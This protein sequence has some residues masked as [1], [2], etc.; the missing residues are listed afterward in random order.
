MFGADPNAIPT[1]R[2][3]R[4]VLLPVP[5]WDQ[6][7]ATAAVRGEGFEGF[8]RATRPHPR[9]PGRF[10]HEHIMIRR[11]PVGLLRLAMGSA[12]NLVDGWVIPLHGHCYCIAADVNNGTLLF[13]IFHGIGTAHVDVFDG[14]VLIPGADQG[15]S[16]TATAM[17]CE[18]VG[19]LSGDREADDKRFAEL[20]SQNPLAPEGSIP[21]HIQKHLARD[22]GPEQLA[23]GGDWLLTMSLLRTMTRGPDY[24]TMPAPR[25][26][27]ASEPM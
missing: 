16:P 5:I 17:L 24:E 15:Y 13:G 21:E 25:D 27:I 6:M 19:E 12:K 1:I 8:F 26:K 14:L 18:R 4:P 3:S 2:A 20:A 7:V 9:M 22:F 23:R 11:D 10:L